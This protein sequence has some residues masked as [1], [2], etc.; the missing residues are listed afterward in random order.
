V[1]GLFTSFVTFVTQETISSRRLHY[2]YS[3]RPW[4]SSAWCENKGL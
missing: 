4:P 1:F 3:H 2:I